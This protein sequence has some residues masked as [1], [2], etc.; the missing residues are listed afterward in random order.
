[1]AFANFDGDTGTVVVSGYLG[2]EGER[3]RSVS[4]WIRTTQQDLSTICYWGHSLRAVKGRKEEIGIQL[5][6]VVVSG[7]PDGSESRVRMIGGYIE[8]FGKG[9]RRRS[10]VQVNDGNFHHVVCTWTKND[11]QVLGHGDFQ[12]AN[13]YV[14]SF[15]EN[16][17]AVGQ[18]KRLNFPDGSVHTS[19]AINT[20]PWV[21][22]VIGARVATNSGVFGGFPDNAEVSYTEHFQGD[23]DE[24]AVYNDVL[25][26]G[27]VLDIYNG[28]TPGVDLLTLEQAAALQFWYRMGDDPGDVVPSGTLPFGTFVDQNP[29]TQRPGVVSSGV[30]IS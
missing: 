20:P 19:T 16:G 21:E 26:S 10:A 14:D 29:F 4:F 18:S 27:T 25:S 23:L 2:I 7:F 5:P 3:H 30:T 1:M 8:L 12:I 9:S 13:I 17:K 22:M 11:E 6:Q 24:F 28:G 15:V